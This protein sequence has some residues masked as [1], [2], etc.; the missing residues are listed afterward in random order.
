MTTLLQVSGLAQILYWVDVSSILHK[1]LPSLKLRA[2]FISRRSTAYDA[3]GLFVDILLCYCG[4]DGC[5]TNKREFSLSSDNATYITYESLANASRG[6][7]VY[8]PDETLLKDHISVKCP[9]TRN[10]DLAYLDT[11]GGVL[12]VWVN[13]TN[14]Y[15]ISKFVFSRTA[16][17]QTSFSFTRLASINLPG[18]SCYLYHQINDTTLAEEQ[19]DFSLDQWFTTYITVP[20]P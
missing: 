5:L 6:D 17:P 7:F 4:N 3:P 13:G 20:N 11:G 2:P 9:N 16:V 1:S 8:G 14:L 18:E 12:A 15:P 10:L 19:Y